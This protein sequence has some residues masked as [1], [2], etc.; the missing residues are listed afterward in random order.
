MFTAWPFDAA[1]PSSETIPA[2]PEEGCAK[3]DPARS[4]L[5]MVRL[6]SKGVSMTLACGIGPAL[7]SSLTEPPPA[8]SAVSENGK[9]DVAEKS[10]NS[11]LTFSRVRGLDLAPLLRVSRPFEI[12]TSFTD[13]AVGAAPEGLVLS[14][15]AGVEGSGSVASQARKIPIALGGLD[16]SDL[17]LVDR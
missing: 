2:I 5:L 16:Q 10:R 13:K 1:F 8:T 11:M 4:R 12:L 3:P 6:R 17:G 7:P 15:A 14:G 9:D